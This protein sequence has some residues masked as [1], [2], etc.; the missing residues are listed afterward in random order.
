[1]E[2]ATTLDPVVEV[3]EVQSMI[4]AHNNAVFSGVSKSPYGRRKIKKSVSCTGY[5]ISPA[6]SL[7]LIGLVKLPQGTP[8]SD[9]RFLANHIAIAYRH[10]TMAQLNRVGGIG[11]KLSWQVTGTA[12]LDNK[13]W[14]ARVSPLPETEE[15][16]TINSVPTIVLAQRRNAKLSDA[17]RIQNWQPVSPDRA[18]I[19]ETVVG[20]KVTLRI[21]EVSTTATSFKKPRSNKGFKRAYP[22]DDDPYFQV[23][24]TT[25][26]HQSHYRPFYDEPRR[27]GISSSHRGGGHGRGRGG[28]GGAGGGGGHG[29]R[30]PQYSGNGGGSGARGGR[31]GNQSRGRGD[32]GSGRGRGRGAHGG[33]RS[34]D[35]VGERSNYGS[36]YQHAQP[37]YDNE[38]Q[39][40][41]LDGY[42]GNYAPDRV[43]S[44]AGVR[45]GGGGGGLPY[46]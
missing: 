13:L 41:Q 9:I 6:D 18:Y 33:Y 20:E 40:A 31:G 16:M 15:Y 21:E 28:G 1:M 38:L 34:L 8:D 10:M 12:L 29:P 3:A 2:G 5:L 43:S 14:A 23:P 44:G 42:G 32:G 30:N 24:N 7:K 25:N 45:G 46:G 35:D 37:S 26:Q 22:Q 17:S 4:N 27:G 19:I 39:M 11:K 36:P